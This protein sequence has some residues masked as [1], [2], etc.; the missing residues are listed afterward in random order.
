MQTFQLLRA[1]SDYLAVSG[2]VS[3]RTARQYRRYA[4]AFMADVLMPLEDVTEDD[5]V[6]WLAEH[7][8]RGP[9]RGQML[10]ALKSYY[11]W[12]L[13][14][15]YVDR[16]PTARIRIPKQRYGRAPALT[17]EQLEAVFAAAELVDP[18]ARPTLELMYATGARLGSIAAVMPEDV[19]LEQA[20]IDFREAKGGQPYGLPL[21]PRGLAAAR[22]LLELRDWHPP[23][24]GGRLPTLV[25]VGPARIRQWVQRAGDLAGIRVWPHLLRHSTITRLAAVGTDVRTIVEFAN[26]RDPSQLRRYAAPLDPNLRAAASV[27]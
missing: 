3:P 6:G 26:W 27:L 9:M 12:A 22:R 21:G 14:R 13:A 10:R 7:C 15:G 2:T 4:I 24:V 20:W 11:R 17:E 18:R 23:K 25:G 8:V 16:D 5:V 19:D 1:W